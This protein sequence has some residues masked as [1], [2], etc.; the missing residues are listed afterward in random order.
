MMIYILDSRDSSE[1]I[2]EDFNVQPELLFMNEHKV[3][4]P[5]KVK[6]N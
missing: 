2:A 6:T 3:Y 5:K 1:T 4:S